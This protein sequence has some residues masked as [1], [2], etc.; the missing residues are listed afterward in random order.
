MKRLEGKVAIITGAGTGIG[1]AIAVGYAREGADISIVYSSSRA[2]AEET[3]KMVEAE[4][5]KG[6]LVQCDQ[7]KPEDITRMIKETYD[8]FGHIDVVVNNAS[9]RDAAPLFEYTVELWDHCI[10]TNLR[11]MFLVMK[12]VAPIMIKQGKGH[13]INVTSNMGIRPSLKPRAAYGSTKSGIIALTASAA[14]ELGPYGIYVN[15]LAPGT[16][17]TNIGGLAATITNDIVKKRIANIPVRR[18]GVAEDMVGPAIF[19]ASDDCAY[20][21]GVTLLADGGWTNAD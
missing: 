6:L 9:A 4:G 10:N 20:V 5:K 17:A 16:I 12:E 8:A 14:E 11:A 18:R 15:A 19:L 7:S 1:R 2:G 13:I 21:D 3:L